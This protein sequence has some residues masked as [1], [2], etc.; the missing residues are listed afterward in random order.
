MA[1]LNEIQAAQSVKII[2]ASTTGVENVPV[3]ASDVGDLL[4]SDIIN[5]GTGTQ[6]AITVTT[7]VIEAKV[8]GSRL[9]NRKLLTVYNN[10]NNTIYWGYTS[11]V[12]SSNGTP[13]VKNQQAVWDI[14]D[15]QA[16]YLIAGSGSNNVR[17]TEGA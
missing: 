8:G 1:D 15:D 10:G 9:S 5:Q 13:I 2:G 16:I 17:V 11:G 7:S 4:V 14:G 12:T 6:G 3:N